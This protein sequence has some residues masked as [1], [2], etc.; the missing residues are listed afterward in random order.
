M[1]GQ[2]FTLVAVETASIQSYIFGS[3]RLK[4]NVGASYLVAAATGEWAIAVIQHVTKQEHITQPIESSEGIAA[5]MIYSGGGNIVALFRKPDQAQAFVR[6]LSRHVQ[7]NAPGLPIT[8]ATRPFDWKTSLSAAVGDLLDEIRTQR[9]YQPPLRGVAG[10]SVSIMGASTSMPAVAMERET[11][12]KDDD[13]PNSWQPYAR[14][15]VIKREA[16]ERANK[17]LRETLDIGATDYRFALELDDLGR[18]KD[19]TSYVAVVHADGNGLGL[20]IQGLKRDYP[21]E[22]NRDYVDYMRWFSNGIKRVAQAAQREMVAQ[23]RASIETDD[24]GKRY[25]VGVGSKTES[26]ELQRRGQQYIFPIRPLVSG[27]D[28]VTFVCDG[29]IGLDL[30]VTFLRAF[31]HYTEQY[32]NRRLS[33]CAGVAIVKTH[34]PFARA[35]ALAD[36]L[37]GEAKQARYDLGLE[38][39]DDAPSAIDWHITA[40]GLYGDLDEMRKREYLIHEASEIGNLTLRP[41]FTNAIEDRIDTQYRNWQVFLE[42]M[43]D[44]QERWYNH[45]NKAEGLRMALRQGRVETAVFKARYLTT[46]KEN[47]RKGDPPYLP[48][49]RGFAENGW[50]AGYCGYYDALEL[51][52]KY[53]P[54]S[55]Q[56]EISS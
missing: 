36:D 26:I 22:K 49:F 48:E 29:R 14:E 41:L 37:A 17:L 50:Q 2:V 34:Y 21:A 10:Q 3:N 31:E 6:T 35:Y 23:I 13:R 54:L 51:M 39:V 45:R 44:F 8:F 46:N 53:I 28:D 20:L 11:R 47:W 4:E 12:D 18:T 1:T 24:N 9:S 40:G 15:T 33:A 5:E 38:N 7:I 43:Q 55:K 30:A 16:S 32:L 25:L 56:R 52:D 27:G 42:I 19:D